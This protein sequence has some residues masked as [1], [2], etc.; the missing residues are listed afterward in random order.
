M[1]TATTNE[2][3]K[4]LEDNDMVVV[5]LWAGSSDPVDEFK[6]TFCD[7]EMK[8]E[9]V[10]FCDVD[11]DSNVEVAEAFGVEFVPMCLVFKQRHLLLQQAGNMPE[12]VLDQVVST[13]ETINIEDVKKMMAQSETPSP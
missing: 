1:S 11:L 8:H 2:L 12:D 5:N 4:I 13:L 6:K 3:N 10:K 9:S 7:V